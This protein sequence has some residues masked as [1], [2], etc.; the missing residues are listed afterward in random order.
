MA[1]YEFTNKGPKVIW[2]PFWLLVSARPRQ[3][4]KNLALFGPIVFEG[5]FFEP[6]KFLITFFGFIIFSMIASGIY[7]LN[8]VID[9]DKDRSHPFKSYRPIAAGKINPLFATVFA[10]LLLI[11]A[12]SL[13]KSLSPFFM[14]AAVAYVILQVV[15]SMFLRSLILVDVMAIAAGFLLRVY[16]GAV[17]IDAH[18]TVWFI[19]TVTSLALF[20]AIGKRRSERT[21]LLAS[22]EKNLQTRE[23]L[24]HY[25]ENL[26]DSLTVM[27]A[28][29]CWLS[30]TMFTFLQPPPYAGPQ[31]LILFG[32]YLPRTFLASKW[33]VAS[34]PFVIFGVMRYLYV[35]Y[36]KKEG[37]SPERVLLSD[38]PL[39]SSVLLWII[40]VFF[41]IYGAS[42]LPDN[43]LKLLE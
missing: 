27:F 33:L 19:L 7:I 40:L 22:K 31:V 35:I 13:A 5:V 10:A 9:R 42:F 32:D 24:H 12:L 3:W 17:L 34:V 29:A 2:I 4:L 37:E 38:I 26:L 25:P 16:A 41:I 11:V 6:D 18:I 1:K 23:I 8:D 39:L 28:T 20:L 36:E 21:L 15:Y 43:L 30:Y 14:F